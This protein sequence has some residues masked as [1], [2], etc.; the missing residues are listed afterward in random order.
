MQQIFIDESGDLGFGCGSRYFVLALVAPKEGRRLSKFIKNFNAHLIGRGWNRSV[1]IKATNVWHAGRNSAIPDT[2]TYKQTPEVPIEKALAA[3][4]ALECRI[5]FV[6][7][8]LDTVKSGLR[9]AHSAILYNYFSWLLLRD[10][11]SCHAGVEL[12]VDR[13]NRETHHNSKFDGYIETRTGIERAQRDKEPL[14]LVIH[15]YHSELAKKFTGGQRAQ[16]EYGVRGL[17][18]ADFVCWAVKRKYENG[19]AQWYA[20]IEECVKCKQV[21][22]F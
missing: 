20:L 1:E 3:I 11:L 7:V 14:N 18:A 17:E 5:E 13:R 10:P 21:L 2:Y 15:H 12:F 6:V 4:A 19:E 16:I 8:R 9:T 22:C